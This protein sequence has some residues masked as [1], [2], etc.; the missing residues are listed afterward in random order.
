MI[1]K[2]YDIVIIGSGAGGG[3][4]AEYVSRYSHLGLSIL[5][6]ESGAFRKK[7]HFNQKEKD[8]SAIY[9]KR[10]AFLSKN[11]SI[12]VA[13]ANTVGGSTAVYTGVS[14]RPPKSVLDD[15]RKKGLSFLTDEYT[16]TVLNEIEDEIHV[17]EL[18]ESWDND[19]NK[20]FKTGAEKLGI[21]VKRLK[22]NTKGCLQQGFCNLGCTSG[23]KQSTLEVQLPKAMQRGVQMIY[24]AEV[25]YITKNSVHFKVKPAPSFSEPNIEKEGMYLVE[26]KVIVVSAGVLQTPPLLF[27][28]AKKLGINTKNLGRYITLHP[29]LNINGIYHST[30]KNYRGFP[31]TYYSD[32][33]SDSHGY[34]LETSFY[35]PGVT[36]K[37]NGGFGADL[38]YIM[39]DYTKMMSILILAHDYAEYNNRIYINSKNQPI[40]D[41][42]VSDSVK[43]SLVHAIQ[44]SASIFFE[45]GCTHAMLPGSSKNI[46]YAEDIKNITSI[47]Q[48]KYLS[49][50]KT[51]LSSAHPQGGCIMGADSHETMV[52]PQGNLWGIDNIF[53]AD[54]SLF[55]TSVKV[56]PYETVMLLSRHVGEQIIKNHFS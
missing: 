17:H 52:N 26:A 10:G 11:L 23:A 49:F 21:Q 7:E 20:L 41:Y 9:Y 3:T 35:Y 50:S 25:E 15:W 54:A 12:G 6:L 33:F 19:N 32:A 55:P 42:T 44:T 27:R 13:A 18:P 30:I 46:V 28:S 51:T 39:K 36:A 29:A 5:V 1:K 8:M 43:K 56:N 37:N 38:A 16:N 34:F 24:N 45:A 14:F 31:K 47:I 2:H 40:L 22:I 4:V 53:V 48:E